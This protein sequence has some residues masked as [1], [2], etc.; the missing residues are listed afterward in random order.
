MSTQPK[1]KK[2][3]VALTT[4]GCK[5]NQFES[6]AFLS[7]LGERDVE[8]VPFSH[9]ADVY[10][11][12][13]C[14]VTAKGGAQSRQV[15]RRAIKTNPKARLVVTGCYSQVAS[16]DVLEIASA[17]ICIVGNGYKHQLVDI[18]LAEEHCDLEM[19]MGD[20][21]R[22]KEICPLSTKSFGERTRAYMKVQDGCNSFCSYCIV[23]YARGRSRS[24][25]LDQVLA[26]AALFAEH[27]YKEVVLT[28][29]HLGHYGLDLEPKTNLTNLV[30]A[31]VE[32][33]LPIRYRLSSLEPTEIT[34]ELLDLMAASPSIMPY[35]HIPLQS[36]DDGILKKMNRRYPAATFAE[37]VKKSA[38]R[39]PG[40]AIGVDVLVGFPG[41]DEAAF[42]NTYELIESLPVSYLHVFPYSKRPGTM[43]ATMAGQLPKKVKEER[44]ALLRDLDNKKRKDFYR[45]HLGSVQ[46]VL[47]EGRK[48]GQMM[49]GFSENYIPVH[50][51]GS[52]NQANT[53]VAVRLEKLTDEGVLGTLVE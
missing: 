25:G 35:L 9:K 1:N 36:G 33:D 46:Q 6:A 5:V 38:E 49:R 34:D 43:A 51:K 15:I 3:K 31:L 12:N 39:L 30:R 4:L 37:K 22:I 52:A 10:I 13:T 14:A 32:Q 29:I 44:V 26:Q 16:Q 18:A 7:E 19:H 23:P 11:V 53:L 8:L 40:V 27:D 45:Q 50:F 17:P 20:I 48:R 24:S 2:L 41:E 47:V 28:G 42:R 21:A